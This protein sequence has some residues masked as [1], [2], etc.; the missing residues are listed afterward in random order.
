MAVELMSMSQLDP[1]EERFRRCIED[2]LTSTKHK[3]LSHL[4]LGRILEWKH[5]PEEAVREYRSVL[6]LEDF[7][8]SRSQARRW[9]KRI[10]G[11]KD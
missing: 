10:E 2:P 11:E 1:A 9:M 4:R 3:A 6:A 5:R 7:E 8:G